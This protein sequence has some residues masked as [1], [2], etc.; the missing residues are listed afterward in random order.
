VL[1]WLTLAIIPMTSHGNDE[2]ESPTFCFSVH[3]K[4]LKT[5]D[6]Y[7]QLR[8]QVEKYVDEMEKIKS[9]YLFHNIALYFLKH[10]V[11][12]CE[13]CVFRTY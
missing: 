10:F 3:P 13:N 7:D 1:F 11:Y 4:T 6:K 8:T 2:I 5:D 12:F 9:K